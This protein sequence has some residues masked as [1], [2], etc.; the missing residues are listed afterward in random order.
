MRAAERW[1]GISEDMDRIGGVLYDKATLV[2]ARVQFG[3]RPRMAS[4]RRK[5]TRRL[6]LPV[7]SRDR[8]SAAYSRREPGYT[9]ERSPDSGV[10]VLHFESACFVANQTV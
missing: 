10:R 8:C 9:A 5:T 3:R 2:R 6:A 4:T 7:Q 1:L